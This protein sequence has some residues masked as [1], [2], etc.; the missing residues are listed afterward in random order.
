MP[1]LSYSDAKRAFVCSKPECQK[2][3]YGHS[4]RWRWVDEGK[5]KCQGPGCTNYAPAGWYYP[6]RKRFFCSGGYIT[7]FYLRRRKP[8]L[9]CALPGCEVPIVR[10]RKR[11]YRLRF[12]SIKHAAAYRSQRITRERA[13]RFAGMLEEFIDNFARIH[14]CPRTITPVRTDLLRF[15][16]FLRQRGIRS[17]KRVTPRTISEFRAW[18]AGGNGGKVWRQSA[19]K[20]VSVFLAWQIRQGYLKGPN[21]V[22]PG[23]RDGCR[24]SDG[25]GWLEEL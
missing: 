20:Y 5:I 8:N 23:P 4:R 24:T 6:R 10:P 13:G 11:G 22:I 2:A 17:L 14:Y 25:H 19:L 1:A 18:E 9:K 3:F 12:C 16:V 15:F 21:P 7:K